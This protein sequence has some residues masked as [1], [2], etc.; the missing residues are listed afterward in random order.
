MSFQVPNDFSREQEKA[1][2]D[3]RRHAKQARKRRD[4]ESEDD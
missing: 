2:R 3:A 1:K 4:Q